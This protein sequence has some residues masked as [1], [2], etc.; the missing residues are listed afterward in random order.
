M[1][2]ESLIKRSITSFILIIFFSFIFL[3]LDIY[4]KFFIYIFYLI[5]FFEI[6]FYFRK[7]IYIFVISNI[8]LFFSLYCLEFYFNNYFI[9]EIFIFTIFII[10]I[11]D[12]SSYL[13]GSK[14]GKFKILPIIS[15]NKTLFGLTSGIFFTLILSLILNYYF[16]IFNFYQCIYFAFITLIFSFFGYL[17]ES[18]LKRKSFLKNSSNFLPGHGGFFDRFDSF[19]MVIIWLFLFHTIL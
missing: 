5:I 3:Y 19:I 8:Y 16:N 12:I 15:P 6:L 7:N 1:A 17:A 4:L 14:Y 11:F 18:Y 2:F 13:L 10:V 9:K